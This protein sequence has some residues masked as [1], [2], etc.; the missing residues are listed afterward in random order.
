MSSIFAQVPLKEIAPAKNFNTFA[1]VVNV[2]V[3]N[4]LV[5]GGLI[6]FVVLV[7]GGLSV[8][9]GAGAGDSKKMESGKKAITGAV[10]GII[11]IVTSVWI[12]QIIE[13]LTGIN[14]LQTTL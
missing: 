11:I 7:F 2:I 1:D 6:L 9:M 10:I 14:I 12:I 5:I 4:A 8:I 13:K 3:K